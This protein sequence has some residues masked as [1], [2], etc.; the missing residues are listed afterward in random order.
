MNGGLIGGLVGLFVFIAFF[1]FFIYP[2]MYD[3][4]LEIEKLREK[5]FDK[6]MSW[7]CEEL[8]ILYE[9]VKDYI[10]RYQN[11]KDAYKEKCT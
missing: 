10:T 2:A 5:Q 9:D 6:Y 1:A 11:L 8:E 4:F 3:D 7:N